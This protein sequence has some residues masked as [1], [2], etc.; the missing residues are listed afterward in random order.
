MVKFVSVSVC[1]KCF[2]LWYKFCQKM[3]VG[4]HENDCLL[5]LPVPVLY[6]NHWQKSEFSCTLGYTVELHTI[7]TR[8]ETGASVNAN[9]ETALTLQWE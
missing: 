8:K 3:H 6:Y 1:V 4:E 5:L 9:S 2:A 7:I